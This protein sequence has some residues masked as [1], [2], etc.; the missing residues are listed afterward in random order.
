[1][2]RWQNIAAIG[3]FLL[4]LVFLVDRFLHVRTLWTDLPNLGPDLV[5]LGKFVGMI[6]A[7]FLAILWGG[8]LLWRTIRQK[9]QEERLAEP[10]YSFARRWRYVTEVGVLSVVLGPVLGAFSKGRTPGWWVAGLLS[11]LAHKLDSDLDLRLFFVSIFLVDA[12]ICFAIL[13]GGYLLWMR[14]GPKATRRNQEVGK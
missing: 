12:A 2:K 6:A 7:I 3:G 4:V 11:S 10:R 8:H 14:F 13:W 9:P 5:D 1:M